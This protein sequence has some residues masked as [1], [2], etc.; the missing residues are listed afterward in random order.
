MTDVTIT[1][2]WQEVTLSAPSVLSVAH[3]P[4]WIAPSGT[5][6]PNSGVQFHGSE[7][8]PAST[9]AVRGPCVFTH[10]EWNDAMSPSM[11]ASGDWSIADA[12][13]SGEATITI[14]TLPD[15]GGFALVS[16]DWSNDDGDT[17]TSLTR[18]TAGTEDITTATGTVLLR[19]TTVQGSGIKSAG[20]SVTVS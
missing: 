16:I 13:A 1:H 6:N 12:V 20:K 14:T 10:T 19:V 17:W 3:G 5:E 2:E 8:F 15:L 18:K 7:F 11:F 9:I 4:C